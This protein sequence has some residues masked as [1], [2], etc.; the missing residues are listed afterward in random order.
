MPTVIVVRGYR[1][2]FY[3]NEGDP[4]EPLHVH[5]AR[6]GGSLKVW[7]EP[8]LQAETPY[9]FNSSEVR[10]IMDIVAGH[11][12]LIRRTWDEHFGS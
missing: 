8:S 4:R 12:G 3:S 6:G 5:V 9:G 10:E 1:L 2:F 11:A 7:L